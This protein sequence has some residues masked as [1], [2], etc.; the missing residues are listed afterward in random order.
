[1]NKR[2]NYRSEIKFR[3]PIS[4]SHVAI[5]ESNKELTKQNLCTLTC[6][7]NESISMQKTH[8]WV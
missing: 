5:G 2:E 7:Q 8:L 4:V 1:M 6:F 3:V